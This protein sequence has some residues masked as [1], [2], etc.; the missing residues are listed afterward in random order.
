M[1]NSDLDYDAEPYLAEEEPRN[2]G[3]EAVERRDERSVDRKEQTYIKTGV[4]G[5][6]QIFR[7]DRYAYDILVLHSEHDEEHVNEMIDMIK[8]KVALP[9]I[10]IASVGENI[11]PGANIFDA[12]HNL[13]DASCSLLLFITP[14]FH[15]DCWNKYRLQTQL[16]HKMGEEPCIIPVLF[17]QKTIGPELREVGHLKPTIFFKEKD[18]DQ[19]KSFIRK[20][21]YAIQQRRDKGN[22]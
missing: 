22:K 16:A 20:I 10:T 1:T 14:N 2:Q 17:G 13:M 4:T 9:D 18:D 21:T 15:T 7:Q 12:F 6:E 3:A 11:P 8:E 5:S 19:Y